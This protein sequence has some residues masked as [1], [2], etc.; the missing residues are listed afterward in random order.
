MQLVGPEIESG[1]LAMKVQS[2][3]YWTGREFPSLAV[4]LF[5][6][7]LF[8]GMWNLTKR[9][10]FKWD[11]QGSFPKN[12]SFEPKK[13]IKR[14][15]KHVYVWGKHSKQEPPVQGSCG[16][17]GLGFGS[18]RSVF[19][20]REV[21][22]VVSFEVKEAVSGQVMGQLWLLLG[23]KWEATGG[24]RSKEKHD[25]TWVS[26]GTFW[27]LCCEH[28]GWGRTEVRRAGRLPQ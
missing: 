6:C 9:N 21:E 7:L 18:V 25:P 8:A 22:W 11:N 10:S 4:F 23:K 3:N 2:P 19:L 27:P 13:R 12:M 24:P 5:V 17:E 20:S 26:E 15:N 14:E 28:A 16:T 1:P